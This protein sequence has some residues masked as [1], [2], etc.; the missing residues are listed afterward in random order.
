MARDQLNGGLLTIGRKLQLQ[1]LLQP[2]T[3][4]LLN[5]VAEE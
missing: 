3:L 4:Q 2:G 5:A 1:L